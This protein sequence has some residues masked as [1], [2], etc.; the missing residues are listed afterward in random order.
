MFKFECNLPFS[1]RNIEVN[2]LKIGAMC[3]FVKDHRPP[4]TFKTQPLHTQAKD[5]KTLVILCQTAELPNYRV[6]RFR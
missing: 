1:I 3:A 4:L 6:V 5:E 2:I